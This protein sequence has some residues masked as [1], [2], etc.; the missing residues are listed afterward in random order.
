[1]GIGFRDSRWIA[2][3]AVF[4]AG[5]VL[6][7]KNSWMSDDGYITVH[8]VENFLHGCVLGF[9]CH[10]R[11]QAYTHPLWMLLLLV[12][13][14]LSG[15]SFYTVQ[16]LSIVTSMAALT[17][18]LVTMV[19]TAPRVLL[20]GLL[21]FASASFLDF[22]SSGLENP[23]SHLC[24]AVVLYFYLSDHDVE[25]RIVGTSVGAGLLML[26][27]LDLALVVAPLV[28]QMIYTHGSSFPAR[29]WFLLL[30]PAYLPVL[31]WE[32][33]SLIY[34]GFA[35]P[36]SAYAKLNT[37]HPLWDR[38][39]Q[40]FLYLIS[41][42]QMDPLVPF[43]LVVTAVVVVLYHG[44][45]PRFSVLLGTLLYAT[46]TVWMGGDFMGGRF[47]T[48][49]V[50]VWAVLIASTEDVDGRVASYLGAVTLLLMLATQGLP[51]H[52][53]LTPPGTNPMHLI[54]GRG[55]ADERGYYNELTLAGVKSSRRP[56]F[57]EWTRLGRQLYADDRTVHAVFN[58]GIIGQ[59]A[60]RHQHLVD[61][62]ALS[63]PLLARVPAL[64]TMVLRP[65]HYQRHLPA[66]LMDSIATGKNHFQDPDLGRY[67]RRLMMVVRAPLFSPERWRVMI[68]LWLGRY[69]HLVNRDRYRYHGMVKVSAPRE[70]EDPIAFPETGA[71]VTFARKRYAAVLALQLGSDDCHR[72]TFFEGTEVIGR[73]RVDAAFQKKKMSTY[74]VAVPRNVQ[75]RGYTR[76]RIMPVE[77]T[78]PFQL[79]AVELREFARHPMYRP[80]PLSRIR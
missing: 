57:H 48:P 67:W 37:G 18:V 72:V 11:V 27:R 63:D 32:L 4:A 28:V 44:L 31:L 43:L 6:L 22:S 35:F 8:T 54:D 71:E 70:G 34:Y 36:N 33:F 52:S 76:V 15:E 64:R 7:I 75:R 41:V 62:N 56:P 21:L 25:Y 61:L 9:N 10:E 53:S 68:N 38:V 14:G 69:D 13:R 74:E 19:K 65:G 17:L 2:S 24:L 50:F 39:S 26:N 78:K 45:G 30:C 12:G 49:M 80:F 20:F 40:G 29:R 42:L 66:G 58:L 47:W 51:W 60:G 5:L 46:Y 23:L 59:A 55:V 77:G 16:F 3:G 79:G 73:S 1:M